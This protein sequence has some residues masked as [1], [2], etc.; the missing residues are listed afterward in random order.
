MEFDA[1]LPLLARRPRR[2]RRTR[3]IRDLVAETRFT[4]AQLVQ[5]LFLVPGSKTRK[6]VTAIPGVFQLSI[7]EAEQELSACTELGISNFMLFGIPTYKDADGSAAW[8]EDGII[9]QALAA[10]VKDFPEA[11][12]IADLCFCEYTDH[13]HCGPLRD[14]EVDNDATLVN[15]QKQA[16]SLARAGV[17]TLA[18]SG[19]MDG[20]VGAVREALD[21]E[22]FPDVGILSYAVKYAS[23][24]YG[25][26]REA[27]ESTPSIGDRHGYQ[28]DPRNASE[29]LLEAELDVAEGADMLMVKPAGMY[30]DILVRLKEA[31][32]LPLAAYQVSG[33]YAM[34]KAAG[35]NGWV[36]EER[37][38]VESLTAIFRAGADAAITYF[39]KDLARVLRRDSAD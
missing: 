14:G 25:P 23:A 19:M 3:T 26:F 22:D 33:E 30:L 39:A 5:P 31:F 8:Q 20:M 27:A 7:D 38:M 36:A 10:F 2:N 32:P 37:V 1:P 17:H 15:L 11:H 34:I 28:M 18:P 16:V 6:E 12:F 24:L 29:A 9:Q 13:G 4:A 21:Q 35:A